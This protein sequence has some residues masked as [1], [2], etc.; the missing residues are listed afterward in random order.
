MKLI[1]NMSLVSHW[2]MRESKF[3]DVSLDL[4]SIQ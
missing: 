3:N 4:L 2:Y 1:Q